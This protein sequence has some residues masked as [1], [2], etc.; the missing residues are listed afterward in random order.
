VPTLGEMYVDML[1]GAATVF[2]EVARLVAEERD[3]ESRAVLMHCTAGKDR[4][5]AAA[6]LLLDAVGVD[7][8]AIVVDSPRRISPVPGATG[9]SRPSPNS[10][11]RSPTRSR[12]S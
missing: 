6:A 2:G 10:A 4:T 12:R 5:G 3:G 1:A 7:R 8:D 9:C 11:S